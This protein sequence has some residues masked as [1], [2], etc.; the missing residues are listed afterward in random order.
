MLTVTKRSCLSPWAFYVIC[1]T[2]LG[3]IAGGLGGLLAGVVINA[4]GGSMTT[5]KIAAGACGF[6]LGLPISFFLYY[7]SVKHF[8]I[9]KIE[10]AQSETLGRGSPPLQ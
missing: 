10:S 9:P 6:V 8:L 7:W 4:A 1:A 5:M 2:I 3:G